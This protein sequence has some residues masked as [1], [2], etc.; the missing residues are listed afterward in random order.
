VRRRLRRSRRRRPSRHGRSDR[1]EQTLRD[2]VAR[3]MVPDCAG[4]PE[5]VARELRRCPEHPPTA[6]LQVCRDARHSRDL[7]GVVVP[8]A[9]E[10]LVEL[11]RVTE[12]EPLAD[13]LERSGQRMNRAWMSAVGAR[14]RAM[15]LAA[16]GDLEA[17]LAA[18]LRAMVH[19]DRL[20]M[21]FERARTLLLLSQ[22]Q[23]RQRDRAASASLRGALS[24]L[25]ELGVPLWADRAQAQLAGAD[26][27][28][29]AASGLTDTE[30]RIA[31]LVASGITNR[32]L[33]DISSSAPRR[34][35]PRLR[36]SIASSGSVRG[37]SW[38]IRW[39]DPPA[40]GYSSV[41]VGWPWQPKPRK[42]G[43]SHG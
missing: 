25:E 13:A 9:V 40:N 18:A 8:D 31:E 35:R 15:V 14:C 29:G 26:V 10:A 36:G 19:H 38:G 37:R 34:W 39:V 33:A 41:A 2:G 24:V 22:F 3:R 43:E 42:F 32:G 21:P 11:G 16:Q 28:P 17:A 12:A 23:R 5:N 1:R 6:H 27:T 20:P 4:F 7:R 30:L